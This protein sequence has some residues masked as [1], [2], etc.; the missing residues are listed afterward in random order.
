MPA[1]A[2]RDREIDRIGAAAAE[3][4][5]RA[6]GGHARAVRRDEPAAKKKPASPRTKSANPPGAGL[7]AHLDEPFGVEAEPSAHREHG[8]KRREVDRVLPLV[9]DDAAAPVTA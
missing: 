4:E 9:V 2:R 7:L 6:V 5:R 8:G 1:L 3:R